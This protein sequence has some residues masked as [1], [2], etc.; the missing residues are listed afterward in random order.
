MANQRVMESAGTSS[1]H[2][3]TWIASVYLS[4]GVPYATITLLA[5]VLFKSLQLPNPTIT[6]TTSLFA[7]PWFIKPLWAP[8]LEGLHADRKLVLIAQSLVA[9]ALVGIATSVSGPWFFAASL[10]FFFLAAFSSAIYDTVSDNLYI[11]ALSPQ[12]KMLYVGARTVFYQLGRLVVQGGFV[13]LAGLLMQRMGLFSSWRCVFALLAVLIVGLIFLHRVILPNP[14][15]GV[16][17]HYSVKRLFTPLK[18]AMRDYTQLPQIGWLML[19]LMLYNFPETQLSRVNALFLLDPLEHGGL[20][21]SVTTTGFIVGV[22]G[23]GAIALGSLL[24]GW[25][26][27]RVSLKHALPSLSFLAVLTNFGY[28]YLANTLQAPLSVVYP[29]I[30]IAQLGYGLSNGAY[31]AYSLYT[32]QQSSYSMSHYATHMSLMGLGSMLAGSTSGYLQ[33]WLGYNDFF[34]W[35]ISIGLVL[36]AFSLFIIRQDR[37]L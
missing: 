10:P 12:Q 1:R 8:L 33:R 26:V 13:V 24:S 5:I 4:Q 11:K 14:H 18:E 19:F 27:H 36:S 25:I 7:I 20:G 15:T 16:R 37:R 29:L 6:L 35:I 2:P 17:Q 28:L 21:L 34:I 3:L 32:V 9:A 22:V 31:M 30:F 23:I